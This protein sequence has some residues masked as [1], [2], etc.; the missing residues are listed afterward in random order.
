MALEWSGEKFS[1]SFSMLCI[2]SVL[3]Y[4]FPEY[5]YISFFLVALLFGITKSKQ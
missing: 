4:H 1:L 3:H 2:G 5:T